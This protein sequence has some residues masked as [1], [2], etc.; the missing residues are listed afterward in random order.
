MSERVK[1]RKKRR[2]NPFFIIL[3][4]TAL[5]LA[6]NWTFQL[7]E[8]DQ[9]MAKKKTDLVQQRIQIVAQNE[10]LRDDIEKLNTPSY[11]EQVAREKLGLVRKGE[12][13]IAPKQAN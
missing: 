2:T 3:M 9:S 1:S 12:I 5:V 6:G 4:G 13:I 10:K 11:I 7:I 8:M